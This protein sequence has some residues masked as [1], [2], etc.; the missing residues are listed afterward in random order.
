MKVIEAL[1]RQ[2]RTADQRLHLAGG[3]KPIGR[4]H[5]PPVSPQGRGCTTNTTPAMPVQQ[6]AALRPVSARR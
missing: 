2:F 1:E 4:G 5:P 3:Q 6:P